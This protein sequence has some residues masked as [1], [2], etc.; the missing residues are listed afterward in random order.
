MASNPDFVLWLPALA[1]MAYIIS[2]ALAHFGK[3]NVMLHRKIWNALLALS[4]LAV[5]ISGIQQ[6]LMLFLNINI[7]LPFDVFSMHAAW[8]MVFIIIAFFIDHWNDER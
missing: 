8:G 3:L 2:Y 6:Y 4:A 7:A 5:A 1:F